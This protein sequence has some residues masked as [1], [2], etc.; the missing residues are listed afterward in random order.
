MYLEF[1]NTISLLIYS[2]I[3][4]FSFFVTK[5]YYH[6]LPKNY[7]LRFLIITIAVTPLCLIFAM[8]DQSVGEDYYHYTSLMKSLVEGN[9]SLDD[10]K[11]IYGEITFNF[12]CYLIARLSSSHF[13][14]LYLLAYTF[15]ITAFLAIQTLKQYVDC[16]LCWLFYLS[17][18]YLQSYNILRQVFAISIAVFAIRFIIEKKVYAFIATIALASLFHNSVLILLVYYFFINIKVSLVTKILCFVFA[19]LFSQALLS[20]IRYGGYLGSSK[21][22]LF[23]IFKWFSQLAILLPL[24]IPILCNKNDTNKVF[25]R[26]SLVFQMILPLLSLLTDLF[27]RVTTLTYIIIIFLS[28]KFSK[29]NFFVLIYSFLFFIA[30]YFIYTFYFGNNCTVY[31]YIINTTQF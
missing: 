31:P 16:P 7:F 10:L 8:R 15:L 13:L 22:T 30:Y 20:A 23:I 28:S 11:Y 25:S 29:Q 17:V 14:S 6:F 4:F 1:S 21:S 19:V 2:G 27:G 26:F 24:S 3:I 9:Y 5:A 18:Y 12:L